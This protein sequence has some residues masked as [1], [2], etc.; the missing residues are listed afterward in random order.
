MNDPTGRL[1][2]VT[3]DDIDPGR[4]DPS[5]WPAAVYFPLIG[6]D[7]TGL[8]RY[9]RLMTDDRDGSPA[10]GWAYPSM[11]T[12]AAC[13][14]V[15]RGALGTLHKILVALDL[16]EIRKELLP[17]ASADGC[18][19]RIPH[20]L[21]RVNDDPAVLELT[22]DA[23]LRVA[24]LAEHDVAVYRRVRHIFTDRFVP[25]GALSQWFRILPVVEQ[26]PVWQRVQTRAS[27][28]LEKRRRRHGDDHG[29]TGQD[30]ASTPTDADDSRHGRAIAL[31]DGRT[32]TVMVDAPPAAA[33]RELDDRPT[34]TT[35]SDVAIQTF[36]DANG[37]RANRLELAMLAEIAGDYDA[38]AHGAGSDGWQ[39]IADATKEAVMSG[40]AFV[41]PKRIER[42][43]SRWA[44]EEQPEPALS[45]SPTTPNPVVALSHNEVVAQSG[46]AQKPHG[47]HHSVTLLD[48]V[49]TPVVALSGSSTTTTTTTTTREKND[50]LKRKKRNEDDETET[51]RTA[52]KGEAHVTEQQRTGTERRTTPEPPRQAT[53]RFTV[54]GGLTNTQL[55][56]LALEDLERALSR[57][58]METWIRPLQLV[59]QDDA[60][61]I[62]VLG[63]PSRFHR[64]RVSAHYLEAIEA[65]LTTLLGRPARDRV[66]L[67]SAWLTAEPTAAETRED[68]LRATID[69][70]PHSDSHAGRNAPPA[71]SS[72]PERASA[73][74]L[75]IVP[76][77]GEEDPGMPPAAPS[78]TIAGLSPA[79][80]WDLALE[81]LRREL[82]PGTLQRWI[83]PLMPSSVVAAGPDGPAALVLHAPTDWH[84][85]RVVRRYL[86]DL[87]AAV[88]QAAGCDVDVRV[89]GRQAGAALSG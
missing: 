7:G 8:L 26:N 85:D 70:A 89:V 23:V 44:T 29:G 52:P 1:L 25:T 82:L 20:N 74:R 57:A 12:T 41:S 39:W 40:S 13:M 76:P 14:G 58:T 83:D 42:I 34:P 9:Y 38:A 55:W 27:A 48:S 78:R 63:A 59:G 62:L 80:L 6:F 33:G 11:E 3:D 88:S 84:A 37:R 68:A 35:A 69:A 72:S 65:S 73:P 2:P 36:E 51:T 77:P 17:R 21:Y 61:R 79:Q 81:R 67:A 47:N 19:V 60:G 43:L 86:P 32:T 31:P 49:T 45:H 30:Q 5:G 71:P 66:D 53:P 75:R 28:D 46:N 4:Q 56:A 50:V 24:R 87:I 15:D 54:D 10:R 16:L 18:V 22:P 64:D